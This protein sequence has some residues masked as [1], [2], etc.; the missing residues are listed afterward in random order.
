LEKSISTTITNLLDAP[1]GKS[2]K[3]KTRLS[4]GMSQ[5]KQRK[6][7]EDGGEERALLSKNTRKRKSFRRKKSYKSSWS[8]K[9]G[10]YSRPTLKKSGLLASGRAKKK[11]GQLRGF[12]RKAQRIVNGKGGL[13]EIREKKL[14]A[15]YSSRKNVD[16]RGK[17]HRGG[18]PKKKKRRSLQQGPGL[19]GVNSIKA[20]KSGGGNHSERGDG[21]GLPRTRL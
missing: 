20:A 21:G 14:S 13:C 9:R 6:K 10:F 2:S 18:A 1:G 16:K 5:K 12:S 15:T 19:K 8:R 7:G 4:K 11:T 17:D 3:G